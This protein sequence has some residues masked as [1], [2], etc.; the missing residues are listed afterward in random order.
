LI[1]VNA[2]RKTLLLLPIG[3]FLAFTPHA[4]WNV[5]LELVADKDLPDPLMSAIEG[6]CFMDKAI[7]DGQIM[8]A[9][10]YG[11]AIASVRGYDVQSGSGLRRDGTPYFELRFTWTTARPQEKADRLVVDQ[12]LCPLNN[13]S[14]PY[15]MLIAWTG[16]GVRLIHSQH[17]PGI[18]FKDAHVQHADIIDVIE[19]VEHRYS[20]PLVR[21]LG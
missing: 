8:S 2:I 1:A 15:L 18:A 6:N 4:E 14:L 16:D 12:N 7:V 10:D 13:Q 11:K 19:G 3:D 21:A 5:S 20:V 17:I 9:A